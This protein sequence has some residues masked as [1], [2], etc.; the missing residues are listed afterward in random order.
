MATQT[1]ESAPTAHRW[2]RAQYERMVEAGV[3]GEDDRVELIEGEVIRMSP[4]G[5]RH[6]TAIRLVQQALQSVYSEGVLVDIQLPLALGRDSE[7]EPD[8]AIVEGSPR[9]YIDAHPTTAVLV[10]EVSDASVDLDRTRKKWLYARHGIGTY[11]ILDL[12]HEH[13]EVYSDPEGTTYQTKRTFH[14][15]DRVEA[16][17]A[18]ATVAVAD[19]LP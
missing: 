14:R 19:L 2:T 4:Q 11:W 10:V 8:V 15:G 5:S 12:A 3:F 7:P 16:P 18:E 6:A 13:L 17:R 9:D 1:V